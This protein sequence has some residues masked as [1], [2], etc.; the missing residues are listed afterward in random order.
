MNIGRRLLMMS[1]ALVTVVALLVVAPA[2]AAAQVSD[3]QLALRWAPVHYQDTASADYDVD[4]LSTVDFDGD[5]DAI[6]NWQ[7][8]DDNLA[9][10]TGAAYYSVVETSTHWFIIYAFYHPR[11]WTDLWDPFDL[12]HHENDM[13]GALLTVRRHTA[14]ADM[15]RLGPSHDVPG[16]EGPWLPCVE[17]RFLSGLGRGRLLSDHR[18]RRGAVQRQRPVRRLPAGRDI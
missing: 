9:W 15:G 4:Y 2:P 11:D 3:Y 12:F 17:R 8:Q 6:N 14:H 1:A 13:E 5:W 18:R 7:H 16:G 10:L